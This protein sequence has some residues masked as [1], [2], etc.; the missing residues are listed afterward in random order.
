MPRNSPL[1]RY[2]VRCIRGRFVVIDDTSGM[3]VRGP[4]PE[5]A[6]ADEKCAGLNRNEQN[7]R[8]FRTERT[9]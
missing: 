6:L 8:K 2:Q 3:I 1:P 4:F 9:A 7:G 5:R